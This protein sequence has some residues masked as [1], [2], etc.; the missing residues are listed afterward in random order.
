M[1]KKEKPDV[2]LTYTTKCSIY[3]GIVCRLLN[4]PSIINNSGLIDPNR[5]G[6]G[7]GTLVKFLYKLGFSRAACMMYQNTS[8]QEMLNGLLKNK[9]RHILL[10]GSG[11]NLQRFKQLDY[12]SEMQ[13]NFLMICRIQKEKGIEEYLYAASLLKP[14]YPNANFWILGGYEEDYKKQVNKLV[15]DGVVSYYEPVKNVIP[16][17]EKSHCVVNPSYH[18]GMSNVLLEASASGRPSIASDCPGCNDIVKNESNGFLV[19][20]ADANDLKE[21]MESFINL[22]YSQ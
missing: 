14:L 9:V 6:K 15:Q 12:P 7:F 22:P 18:E 1:L 4:I 16:Y 8:E 20:V 3:G 2:V 5:I 13:T 19:K 11:V 17:I 10:P 21:K